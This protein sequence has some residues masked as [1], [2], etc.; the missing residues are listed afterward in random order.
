MPDPISQCCDSGVV[1]VL[2]DFVTWRSG[3]T[4]AKD[5]PRYWSGDIPWLTPKDM[6]FFDVEETCDLLTTEGA[7]AGSRLAPPTAT[8]VVV[9]GMILAHTFPVS[10]MSRP[11]AFNQDIKAVLPGAHLL[12]RYLAYWLAGHADDFL[13]V[14]GESTHGTKRVRQ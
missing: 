4:P 3:G 10:Q 6:K 14:V 2:D 11:S 1:G 7:L 5:N 13:R 8:Y 12:P 9:R